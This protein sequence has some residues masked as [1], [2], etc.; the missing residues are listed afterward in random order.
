[1]TRLDTEGY[2][3]RLGFD[4]R[5]AH[6]D[7][8]TLHAL[9]RAQ[10]ERVAYETVD[11]HL[12]RWR[13][14]DPHDSAALVVG[15]R[16]GYCYQL[17]GALS[18]L[19]ADLGFD[20]VWHRAGV[21]GHAADGPPGSAVANHLAL[22]VHG[23]PTDDCPSGDWLVDTGL[24]DAI[25]D[26]LPLHEGT[27]VQGPYRFELRPSEVEPGGWRL[28]HDPKG[29]FVGMD[30]APWQATV[31]HFAERH[32]FLWTSPESGFVRICSVQR[33]DATGV[34]FLKGCLLG[35]T[36]DSA[37]T[38]ERTIETEAEWFAALAD[39]FGM[40][41]PDVG[42]DERHRLWSRLRTAHEAWLAA[43]SS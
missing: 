20:V 3:R 24:G 39:V 43:G 10:V 18:L 8:A 13:T 2:L 42:P 36:A 7:V 19:L 33:R 12:E 25:H 27:Y 17:N 29:S 1:M 38:W 31:D 34:D 41:L 40:S 26:P 11:I 35:H 14:I 6:A 16:G 30:F 9:H 32:E 4:R 37:D 15:G 23:L 22:T 28:D 21:Q 5:P